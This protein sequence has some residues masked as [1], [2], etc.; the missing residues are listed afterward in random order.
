MKALQRETIATKPFQT[1]PL[2]GNS[3]NEV[4]ATKPLQQ[5]NYKEIITAKPM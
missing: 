5:R 4:F 2:Q 3:S 1:K